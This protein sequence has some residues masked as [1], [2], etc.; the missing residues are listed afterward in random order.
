MA[1]LV[2]RVPEAW[3]RESLAV[4]RRDGVRLTLMGEEIVHL[5]PSGNAPEL[6]LYVEAANAERAK[7]LR[8]R[9]LAVVSER[10]RS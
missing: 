5:R 1:A 2:E 3:L 8:D 9:W 10:L 7:A 4:D 6:R